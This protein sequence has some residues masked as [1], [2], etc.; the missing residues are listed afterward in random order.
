MNKRPAKYCLINKLWGEKTKINDQG[1]FEFFDI[2]L[3][4][5]YLKHT[6]LYSAFL[7][8]KT[9]PKKIGRNNIENTQT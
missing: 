3:I 4:M 7:R 2:R 5:A 1:I 6:A 9:K 8:E